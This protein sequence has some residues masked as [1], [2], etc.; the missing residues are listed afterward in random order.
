MKNILI[1]IFVCLSIWSSAQIFYNSGNSVG[2]WRDY[3]TPRMNITDSTL[4]LSDYNIINKIIY[5]KMYIIQNGDTLSWMQA[6]D[7]ANELECYY[8]N[9]LHKL[10]KEKNFASLKWMERYFDA[11]SKFNY[12][13]GQIEFII[14]YL[15]H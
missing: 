15:K 5:N 4:S 11:E 14:D 2:R 8:Y 12:Y 3:D 6:F 9:K 7:K 1:I 10:E 13:R